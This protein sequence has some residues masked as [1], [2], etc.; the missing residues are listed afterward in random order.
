MNTSNQMKACRALLRWE[1]KELAKASGVNRSTIQRMERLGPEHWSPANTAKVREALKKGGIIFIKSGLEGAGIRLTRSREFLDELAKIKSHS[2]DVQQK[3]AAKA[4]FEHFKAETHHF[5]KGDV[6]ETEQ[7]RSKL[8]HLRA[9]L[10]DEIER[11]GKDQL[12]FLCS[13]VCSIMINSDD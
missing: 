12:S 10:E 7:I 4:Q 1:Q 6:N 2:S 3:S 11:R 5:F 13:Y 9:T 8:N